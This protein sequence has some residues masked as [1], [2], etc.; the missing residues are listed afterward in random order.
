MSGHAAS[1]R[2]VADHRYYYA[3]SIG[4]GV[5]VFA[6]FART[7]YLKS[8]FGA[9]GLPVL[10]HAHGAVMTLWYA[11]FA[12]Q[13]RLAATHRV[14]LHRKL[15][16]AGIVLAGTVAVLSTVVSL[17]LARRDLAATGDSGGVLLLL[18]F[19]LFG[20]V[21]VFVILVSLALYWRRRTD[22]HKRLMVLA[23]LSVLGPALTRLPLPF[24]PNHDVSVAIVIGIS[25]VLI[26]IIADT[27][28][29]RR[30][31][32]AFGWGGS[33]VIGSIFI[34]AAFAQSSLWFRMAPWLLTL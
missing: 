16:I 30:L 31:H 28:R 21:L 29:S 23:M 25:C 20:I 26:C 11:L 34:V 19:Q 3:V 27:I 18:A 9:P 10:L 15:G 13:V 22:Y 14:A 5:A 7:Y 17:G 32:P 6:G 2:R 33:L 4:L 1:P 8:L 24:L 12:V